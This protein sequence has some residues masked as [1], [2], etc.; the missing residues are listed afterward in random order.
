MCDRGERRKKSF[1]KAI[2][3]AKLYEIIFGVPAKEFVGEIGRFKKDNH[4]DAGNYKEKTNSDWRGKDNFRHG[5]RKK[6]EKLKEQIIDYS[7]IS[8]PDPHEFLYQCD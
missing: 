7:E 8:K 6:Y 4:I 1:A 5:E 3:S 2:R